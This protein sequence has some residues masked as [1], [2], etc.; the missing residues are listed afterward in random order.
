MV[1]CKSTQREGH[2]TPPA[3]LFESCQP[4]PEH[5]LQLI[6]FPFSPQS[7]SPVNLSSSPAT[8]AHLEI[9]FNST[10]M[11]VARSA[12]TLI[13]PP[14]VIAIIAIFAATQP[15]THTF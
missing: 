5:G 1:D 13:A 14:V 7:I 9:S 10:L 4:V 3:D 11:H 15:S 12:F 2:S 6:P 8:P